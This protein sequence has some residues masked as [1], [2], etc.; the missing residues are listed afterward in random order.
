MT[1]IKPHLR[2]V[3][4]FTKVVSLKG[5]GSDLRNV[6]GFNAKL[7]VLITRSVGTMMCAYLFCFI[8]LGSLPAV[9]NQTG[10]IPAH[11]FPKWMTAP[12]LILIVT[13]VAQTFIQLVLLAVIMVGQSVQGAAAEAR[14]IETDENTKA[15]LDALNL[16]TSGGLR[17]VLDAII[18]LQPV[19]EAPVVP[20]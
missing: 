4:H 18:A 15:L 3:H 6:Q 20:H 17:T 5:I 10:W 8:A 14:A 9:L 11:T 19:P 13:W 1:D 2:S 7:A 12:G 16:E